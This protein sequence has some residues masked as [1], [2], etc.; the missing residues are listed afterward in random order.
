MM[1]RIYIS[2]LDVIL[3]KFLN[4]LFIIL[5]SY[6]ICMIVNNLIQINNYNKIEN[7]IEFDNINN[8][9]KFSKFIFDVAYEY[10]NPNYHNI[11]TLK[12]EVFKLNK[13]IDEFFLS[14]EKAKNNSLYIREDSKLENIKINEV[15]DNDF[16]RTYL[17]KF[18]KNENSA[19]ISLKISGNI[20]GGNLYYKEFLLYF[21]IDTYGD[22]LNKIQIQ[23]ILNDVQNVSLVDKSILFKII[24]DNPFYRKGKVITADKFHNLF[25]RF[26]DL[27]KQSEYN[28]R[29]IAFSVILGVILSVLINLLFKLF[30]SY[31][32]IYKR[33]N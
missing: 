2:F 3:E 14:F 13:D 18:D 20:F 5:L 26:I 15:V 4:I 9:F 6:F 32:L 30:N 25:I 31:L 19:N 21:D 29:V 23:P 16:R 22:S 10:P 1:N 7:N 28:I 8:N 27:E 11:I 12:F 17:F 24:N 33:N